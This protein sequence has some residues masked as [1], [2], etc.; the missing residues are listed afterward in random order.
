[1]ALP[2]EAQER[3]ATAPWVSRPEAQAIMDLLDG[4]AGR[5]R[6]VGGAVR[7]VLLGRFT[8]TTDIDMATELVP[9]EVSRRAVAAGIAV[10]PTGIEHGTVTLKLGDFTTEV[11]TLREDVAT[12]GRHAV[13]RFGHDWQADAARRDFTMNALYSG[14]DGSLFDPLA[15]VDD[16]LAGHVRFIGDADRRIAEDRLRVFR[17]FRFSASHGGE[18]FDEP[19]LAASARAAG[20]LGQLSPE[21]VGAEMLRMLMLPSIAK[22]LGA[23]GDAGILS[24]AEATRVALEHYEAL[25]SASWLGRATLLAAD[26]GL[27]GLRDRWRLSNRQAEAI[28]AVQAVIDLLGKGEIA[29]AFYEHAGVFADAVGLAPVLL[30]WSDTRVAEVL[31]Q[32][33]GSPPKFPVG[34]ADLAAAGI[35][36]G[37]GM[38]AQL[39]LLQ[40][41]W[42]ESGFTLTRGELLEMV[43][44]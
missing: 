6:V 31:G 7:D 40:D 33:S 30:D 34:G 2:F 29:R 44:K 24:L 17:F 26:A 10:Y 14:M 15:G 9:D 32:F 28:E 8:P 22:T 23:M 38:G 13:V 12:D 16:C 25:G 19:G 3:L 21:R 20:D 18:Q 36:P 42:I 27:D 4:S 43:G 41:R 1:M 39:K 5:V 37:K 11:T 35:A